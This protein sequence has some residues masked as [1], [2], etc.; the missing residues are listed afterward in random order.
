MVNNSNSLIVGLTFLIVNTQL[1]TAEDWP[2]WRG[3]TGNGVSTETELPVTW[4]TEENILWKLAMPEWTGSTPIVWQNQI[5]LSV[6]DGD[7]LE[8]W[9]INRNTGQ[10]AWKRFLG[11]GNHRER[12]QNMSSPSPVTDGE[13]VW[14]MTGTGVL[15]AFDYAGNELWKRDIPQDYG[16]FGLMWGYASSPLLHENALYIQVLHGM[17]TDDPSYILRIDATT[18]DTVWREERSTEALNESPDSYTTPALLKYD[19]NIEI[20]ITGGDAVSGHD[21]ETGKEIWRADGL[22]PARQRNYRVV[23]SPVIEGNMIYAPTRIRPLLALKAGGRG[24]V[25]QSHVIW[26][27]D[28]GPDVPTPV[29]DGQYFYIINDSGIVYV[30][31]AHTG[32]LIYGKQRLQR[33]TYSSSPVLADGKIFITNESG[34]TTVFATGPEFIEL[35]R[36]PLDDYCLSSPAIS[37]G[38][39]FIRTAQYLWAIGER[40]SN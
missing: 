12:K 20:V 21:P 13:R 38:Q 36:N 34:L 18:G 24:D 9:N 27:T 17:K 16:E 7:K 31:D 33:G 3:P 10:P 23:A 37:E 14:V 19:G 15:K 2:T 32:E 39:I 22:N 29:T 8:L 11:S 25:L 4:D 40:R 6:A 26:K 30:H 1:T 35:S 5:F 28:N